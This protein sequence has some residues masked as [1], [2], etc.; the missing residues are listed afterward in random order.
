MLL[1]P[2]KQKHP[3]EELKAIYHLKHVPI[4]Y[5]YHDQFHDHM[6]NSDSPSPTNFLDDLLKSLSSIYFKMILTG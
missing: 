6:W 4:I 1:K 5:S 2:N 3:G